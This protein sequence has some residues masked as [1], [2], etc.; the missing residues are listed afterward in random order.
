M[1]FPY[2]DMIFSIEGSVLT[3]DNDDIGPLCG[4]DAT[5]D[6]P[7]QPLLQRQYTALACVSGV[8]RPPEEAQMVDVLMIG[9]G[10][11]LIFVY[12]CVTHIVLVVH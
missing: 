2:P 10:T 9:S 1:M 5:L 8:V 7:V 4:F 3:M 11:A 12:L 6:V